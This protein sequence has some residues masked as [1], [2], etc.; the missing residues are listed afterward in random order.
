M[1]TTEEKRRKRVS[2]L[3]NTDPLDPRRVRRAGYLMKKVGWQELKKGRKRITL[4]GLRR[5]VPTAGK[6]R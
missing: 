2:R 6:R 1:S 3:C 4:R 5:V